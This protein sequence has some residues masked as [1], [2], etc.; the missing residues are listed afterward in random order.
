MIIVYIIYRHT[1]LY[2]AMYFIYLRLSVINNVIS[3]I[4]LSGNIICIL[5]I[6]SFNF[7]II[8]SGLFCVL[9][10]SIPVMSFIIIELPSMNSGSLFTHTNSSLLSGV[11]SSS[12]Q[13]SLPYLSMLV[14]AQKRLSQSFDVYLKSL[15][16]FFRQIM[17]LALFVST[18]Y[19]VDAYILYDIPPLLHE[20]G[21]SHFKTI[22]SAV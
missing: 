4:L 18:G 22:P 17:L 14:T 9:K 15:Q 19:I 10:S 6:P 16:L 11:F 12:G 2:D 7:L 8:S 1:N 5:Y 21:F 3:L 20:S 13:L